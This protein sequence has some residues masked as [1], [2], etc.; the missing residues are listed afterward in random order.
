MK[1]IFTIIFGMFLTS[2]FAGPGTNVEGTVKSFDA[3][4]FTIRG[5]G[6]EYKV[7]R[8]HLAKSVDA[9]FKNSV[10]KKVAFIVPLTS[11][12]LQKK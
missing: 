12:T 7:Q 4:T 3:N 2:A 10:G 8:S 6:I 11:V 1:I 9:Y 5:K